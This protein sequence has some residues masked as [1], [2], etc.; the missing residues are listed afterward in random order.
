MTGFPIS[1]NVAP[2]Y[3][4]ANTAIENNYVQILFKPGLALQTREATQL[5]DILQNQISQLGDFV[6]ADGSPVQGGHV[7][8][9]GTAQALTLQQQYA[10]ADINLS[11]FFVNGEPTLIINASGNTIIKAVVIGVDTTQTNPVIVVKYLTGTQFADGAVIQVATGVQSQAQLQANNSSSE[12]SVAS[13]S[14]G[15]FYSGGYFVTVQPTTIVISSSNSAPTC[16]V[17]L[18]IEASIINSGEDSSLLDP[19]QGSFNYQAPGADRAQYNLNLAYRTFDSTDTTAFYNLVTIENGLITSQVE[20][21]VLGTIN[22]TLAKRTYD[23]NGDFV[24]KPFIITTG[25]NQANAEQYGITVSPGEAFVKGFEFETVGAQTLYADKA[26]DTNTISDYTFSLEYGNIL[27]VTN[28]YG[29]NTSGSFNIAGYQNVDV[30]CV[31][32]GQ[33]VNGPFAG[34]YAATKMGTARVRDIETNGTGGSYFAYILD[35]NL[36]PN[37]LIATAGSANSFTFPAT[38]ANVASN[39]YANVQVTINTGGFIDQATI[40]SYNSSNRIATLDRLL[41]TAANSTSNVSL[42]YGISDIDSLVIQPSGQGNTYYTQEAAN[43][44][45]ACMDVSFLGRNINGNTQLLDQ[46]FNKLIWALPQSPVEQNSINDASFGARNCLLNQSFANTSLTISSGS[47]LG[48]QQFFP[49]GFENQLLPDAVATENFIVIVRN[50]LSSNLSNGQVLVMNRNQ[51][52]GSAGNG[53]FQVDT[54][55]VTIATSASSAFNGDVYFTVS[56]ANASTSVRRTKTLFGNTS[57]VVLAATDTYLNGTA[58]IG[59]TGSNTNNVYIDTAN[60]YVWYLNPSTMAQTPGANQ[61]LFVPDVFNVIKVYDSGNTHFAP[62]NTNAIDITA[63]YTLNSGQNDNYYDWASL[64]LKAGSNAPTG[65]T[66]VMMQYF[67]HTSSPGFFDADSY[68][69]T[70][71]NAQLIPFY[72]SPAFGTF[73]L[74]DSID[75]RPTRQL[76][77]VSS[78]VNFTTNGLELPNPDSVFTLS[79]SFYLPR[80][81]KLVLNKGGVFEVVEGI[82]AQYPVAPADARDAMTLYILNV[83]AFTA[84]VQQISLQYVE[85]KRYTM[86]DIGKLDARITQLEYQSTMSALEQQATSETILYQDN[87]TAKDQYGI[88]ADDFGDFS[89]VDNQSTDL[90]CYMQQGTLSPFKA[91]VPL[92]LNFSSNSAAFQENDRTYTL[93]WTETPA[94][95]QN[96]A[97]TAVSVQPY[98]FAQ[99]TGTVKLTPETDYWFSPTLTPAVIQPPTA[100]PALP[101]LPKPTQAPALIPSANVAPPSPP[102]IASTRVEIEDFWYAPETYWY[103]GFNGYTYVEV[104][105]SSSSYGVVSPVTNWFGIPTAAAATASSNPTNIPQT[106]SSIQLPAGSSITNSTTISP[107]AIKVL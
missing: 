26:L 88:I 9:D 96:A 77:S 45:D 41:S 10:N 3:D 14:A 38:F 86:S 13:I 58:V 8:F 37:T 6:L 72:N 12:A 97:T 35:L 65:Q 20:Y 40:L 53:V 1:L 70:V 27:T 89:I 99:F 24:V 90:R 21:P 57:N 69:S 5:Q 63:N 54:T 22:N 36:T 31:A 44:V 104:E 71:Y 23:T 92:D 68:S 91:T 50:A 74:R 67:A 98:L 61:S 47:G 106:G 102:V 18:E 16:Y 93:P 48:T 7:S 34:D 73:S 80:I 2:Y 15:V 103:N 81:D 11:D 95:V 4:D 94:V 82:S 29:G 19:A 79:Y 28:L 87:V 33:I 84:N 64:T 55:H 32:S 46:Q 30:H 107:N 43:A 51:L 42:N 62:N 49:Y 66:V 25:V 39:A 56:Q 105:V 76:G 59:L 100:N 85:Q 83:P 78:V 60:G 101:P 52:G 75:F 17:G